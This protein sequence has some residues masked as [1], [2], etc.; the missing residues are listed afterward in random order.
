MTRSFMIVG[1]IAMFFV[2]MGGPGLTTSAQAAE[3]VEMDMIMIQQTG[4]NLS[5][6]QQEINELHAEL[7]RIMVR[8]EGSKTKMSKAVST[9]CKSIPKSLQASQFA[10]GICQ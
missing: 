6:L 7:Q 9:Y 1:L 5:A 8:L 10:P 4:E 3:M 2:V